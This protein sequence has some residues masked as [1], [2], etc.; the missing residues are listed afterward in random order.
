MKM[1]EMVFVSMN[2]LILKVSDEIYEKPRE[3]E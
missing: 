1:V 3:V 2:L